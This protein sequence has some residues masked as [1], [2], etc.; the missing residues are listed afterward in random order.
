MAQLTGRRMLNEGNL[1][2]ASILMYN[3]V[4]VCKHGSTH[5]DT[6][7]SSHYTHVNNPP[8]IIIHNLLFC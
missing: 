2:V 6:A 3:N 1:T 5:S 8:M 7:H 4:C